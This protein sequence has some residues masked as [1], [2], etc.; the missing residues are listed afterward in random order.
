MKWHSQNHVHSSINVDNH[1]SYGCWAKPLTNQQ[2]NMT[3]SSPRAINNIPNLHN[4]YPK[5]FLKKV[6]DLGKEWE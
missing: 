6:F 5:K 4:G 3:N 2:D 1:F